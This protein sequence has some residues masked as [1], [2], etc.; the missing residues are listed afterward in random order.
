MDGEYTESRAQQRFD[1]SDVD[2]YDL[3]EHERI[4]MGKGLS[5]PMW[6]RR[7]KELMVEYNFDSETVQ[8]I[9]CAEWEKA[10]AD[11]K[12][13]R[14]ESRKTRKEKR[15]AK[16][17]SDA[18]R[19]DG[20]LIGLG[21]KQAAE[22]KKREVERLLGR[23]SDEDVEETNKVMA[24]RAQ[25]MS[26][27]AISKEIGK[28]QTKVRSMIDNAVKIFR[29]D[30]NEG[31]QDMIVFHKQKMDRLYFALSAKID[32]GDVPAIMAA[33]KLLER[34]AKLF[35]MDAPERVNVKTSSTV[36]N[37]DYGGGTG[38]RPVIDVVVDIND[39]T[40]EDMEA[41]CPMIPSMNDR[42]WEKD[43]VITGNT[44]RIAPN[45]GR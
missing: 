17:L 6:I 5:R 2:F 41:E 44:S 7:R 37:I 4:S 20:S 10:E 45:D 21:K 38:A 31:V 1:E 16:I 9:I 19:G 12:A 14:A 22:K 40:E 29:E 28:P 39:M 35:G 24:M 23:M 15:E 34:E 30:L 3:I 27:L 33:V 18:L 11:R 26:Y 42:S 13:N 8:R 36:Y 25:G 32:N 43:I